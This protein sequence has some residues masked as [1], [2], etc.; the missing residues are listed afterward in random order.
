MSDPASAAK[1]DQFG[2]ARWMEHLD[3]VCLALKWVKL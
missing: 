2:Q 1:K 3:D